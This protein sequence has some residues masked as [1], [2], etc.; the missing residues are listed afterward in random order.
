MR[1][2]GQNLS[3]SELQE[4]INEIDTSK[5]G[6]IEFSEFLAVTCQKRKDADYER[7]IRE[8]FEVFDR[9]HTGHITAAGL[10]HVLISLGE[11]VTD[12]EA[13]EIIRRADQDG[14]GR[15]SCKRI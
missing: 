6:T 12:E 2:L 9:D 5:N 14:D 4:I 11:D 13:A 1:S 10:R 8:A 3:Q 15:V 7:E